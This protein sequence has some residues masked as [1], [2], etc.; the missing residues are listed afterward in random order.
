MFEIFALN[1]ARLRMFVEI[2]GKSVNFLRWFWKVTLQKFANI[3]R[4]ETSF[5]Q[6]EMFNDFQNE[7]EKMQSSWN[8]R[9][10]TKISEP[11]LGKSRFDAADV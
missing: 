6:Y 9:N 5:Y 2:V 3:A 1:I 8:N 7:T 11:F 10:I 4:L